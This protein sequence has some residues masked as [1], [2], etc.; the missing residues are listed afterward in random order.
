MTY[1]MSDWNP[2]R[3]KDWMV[4]LLDN[5]QITDIKVPGL[6]HQCGVDANWLE[7]GILANIIAHIHIHN[8]PIV[9]TLG[10][11]IVLKRNTEMFG[12]FPL[13]CQVVL[14]WQ[15]ACLH[16]VEVLLSGVSSLVLAVPAIGGTFPLQDYDKPPTIV[17]SLFEKGVG[18]SLHQDI[19][20]CKKPRFLEWHKS[21]F[22]KKGCS[23]RQRVYFWERI[24][25]CE[26]NRLN[27]NHGTWHT[28]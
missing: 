3:V 1:C 19:Y 28:L 2:G 26:V 18:W 21:F 4:I 5:R 25:V 23:V 22:V 10:K 6:E 24:F 14:P 17:P 15:Q 27:Y 11:K 9:L 20:S 8:D 12:C 16:C 13:S 7:L